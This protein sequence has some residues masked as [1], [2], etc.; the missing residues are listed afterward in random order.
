MLAMKGVLEGLKFVDMS[1][2]ENCV[3][4]KKKRVSFTK[5]ARELKK[6][7]RTTKQVGVGG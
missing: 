2:C 3:M 1:S 5:I 7:F 4:S 6:G